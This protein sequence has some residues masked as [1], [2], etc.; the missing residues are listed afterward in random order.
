MSKKRKV[1]LRDQ[2]F[3]EQRILNEERIFSN[4]PSW[5]FAAVNYLERRQM[6]DRINISFQRGQKKTL[7]GGHI[8]YSLE[9]A[10]SVLDKI[11]GTPRYWR[12]RKYILFAMLENLGPFAWFFTLS[13]A[14]YRYEENFTSLLQD[15]DITY[16]M[17]N[18]VEKCRID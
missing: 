15:H 5:V 18:G 7:E 12:Q 11:K 9:D 10:F 3:F 8:E 14:D 2:Q 13:C 17:E 1:K 16:I 4:T 6:K